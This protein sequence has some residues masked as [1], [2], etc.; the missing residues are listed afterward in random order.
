MLASESC[1]TTSSHFLLQAQLQP[2][3]QPIDTPA[4]HLRISLNLSSEPSISLLYLSTPNMLRSTVTR[5]LP[6]SSSLLARPAVCVPTQQRFASAH[7]IS[8]PTLANIE[9]R[10]EAMPPQEQ[11]ELWMA[12]RDRMKANWSEL[13]LQEKKAG[14]ALCGSLRI[15]IYILRAQIASGGKIESN[16]DSDLLTGLQQ[17]RTTSPSVLTVPE[18]SPLQVKA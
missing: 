2:T 9:K 17:Q 12:L 8:N 5:A 6:R 11:A 18:P 15:S 4:I 3:P 10:W 7:A 1:T 14:M 13:T 16:V